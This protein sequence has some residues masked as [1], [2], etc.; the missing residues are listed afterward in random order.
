MICEKS[1]E[2]ESIAYLSYQK[3][4][5]LIKLENGIKL[6]LQTVYYHESSYSNS[7]ITQKENK[8]KLSG[9]YH[10]DERY[11]HEN[12]EKIVRLVNNRWCK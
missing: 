6:N 12:G 4:A 10:Y 9:I 2:Y 11:L 1:T 3:K 5:E 7:L 8:I